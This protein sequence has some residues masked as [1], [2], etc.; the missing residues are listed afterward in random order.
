MTNNLPEDSSAGEPAR[1]TRQSQKTPLI[2]II[3]PAFNEEKLIANTLRC[4]SPEMRARY[5]MELIV[6]DGGSTDR[7]VEIARQYA[8]HIVEH[9][10]SRR[11]TIAE[12]RNCGAAQAS[13]ELLVFINADTVPRDSAEFARELL[14][15]ASSRRRNRRIVAMTCPIEIAPHERKLVD[16]LMHNWFN[17]N[18]LLSNTYGRGWSRGECQVVWRSAFEM[19]GG[20]NESIIC[21]EDFELYRRL[22]KKGRIVQNRKL[23][24]YESPRRFRKYGYVAVSRLW[25]QESIT[26]LQGRASRLDHYEEVR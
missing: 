7:T 1:E 12:G 4:F 13:G 21:G 22:K 17:F 8:D 24:V 19:V 14:R 5:R 2:S 11:Q 10:E 26:V 15:L 23:A 16:Y 9:H 25:I 6:S 18:I 20:Y 3:V